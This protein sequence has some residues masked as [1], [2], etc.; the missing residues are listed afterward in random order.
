MFHLYITAAYIFPNIYVYFRIRKLFIGRNGRMIYSLLYFLLFSIYPAGEWFSEGNVNPFLQSLQDISGYILPFFLYLFLFVLVY[1]LFRVVNHLARFISVETM[2]KRSYRV[3]MLNVLILL[4][5][6]V[7][8]A[9]VINMNTIRISEYSIGLPR[10]SSSIKHLKVAFTSDI[11]LQQKTRPQFIEQFVRKVNTQNPDIMLYTGDIVEGDSEDESTRIIESEMRK[12]STKYGTF[13]VP[14]NHEYYG[15]KADR[16]FFKR[17]GITMLCDT[18]VKIDEAFYLAG[19][20]DQ[21]SSQRKNLSQ[22]LSNLSDSLPVILMDH[23]PTELRDVSHSKADV[24]LSGHTHNGQMFPINLIT[25]RIYDLSW[26]HMKM[27]NTHFFVT[28]GLR[29][30]GPPVRTAGKSEIMIINIE[31]N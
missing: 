17:F 4:S 2:K 15:G 26:G 24:Q 31:F 5:I 3:L 28:S 30:W 19:R 18:V 20:N 8:I 29:L 22:L 27:G 13:G 10:K 23:R 1:D 16:L 21:H 6:A 7:V 11:H 25:K 9:G 14:G 12:I